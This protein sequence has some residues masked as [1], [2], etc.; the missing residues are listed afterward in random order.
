MG[1]F[2]CFPPPTITATPPDRAP[3]LDRSQEGQRQPTPATA[4]GLR[5]LLG[6]KPKGAS[7]APAAR[8]R[9]AT[10]VNSNDNN[11][12]RYRRHLRRHPSARDASSRPRSPGASSRVSE[13]DSD[14]AD[15]SNVPAPLMELRRGKKGGGTTKGLHGRRSSGIG[16]RDA[17]CERWRVPCCAPRPTMLARVD[18]RV[19][20]DRMKGVW[21]MDT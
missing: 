7:A 3:G 12:P 6:I 8:S 16:A 1:T 2:A 11:H 15:N 5:Q 14:A 20:S 17:P 18:E 10:A 4:V 19:L 13:S 21:A 9:N